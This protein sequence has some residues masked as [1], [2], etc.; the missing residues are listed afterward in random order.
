MAGPALARTAR[1]VKK[2]YDAAEAV[3]VAA[4]FGIELDGKPVLTPARGMLA[5][6]TR[7]LADAIAAEWNAQGERIDPRALPLTGLAYAA[8]DRVAPDRNAFAAGLAVYGAS[9]L[10][11][12]RAEHPAPLVERQAALWDPIL[13]WARRRYDVDFEQACGI[14]P[15]PQPPATLGR[16]SHAVHAFSDFELAAMRPLVTIS[17]S[18]L[19]ALAL[20][21]RA[22][23]ADAAWAAATLDEQWQAEKW[24]EDPE[25]AKA[26]AAR[27]AEFEAACRF[28]AL[29]PP[30][31]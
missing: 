27:R 24:G 26:L 28:L 25:A 10:L 29:L 17:G 16:L 6:P 15:T 19:I 21:E 18:L 12:Y 5:V 23:G 11:C 22:I 3:A 9:D 7:A 14:V 4:G 2:F 31:D 20:A 8:I 1:A 30:I 13:S